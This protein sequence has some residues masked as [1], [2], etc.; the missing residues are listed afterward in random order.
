MS[1]RHFDLCREKLEA[2]PEL[3]GNGEVDEASLGTVR[4]IFGV[5]ELPDGLEM[6]EELQVGGDGRH[7]VGRKER[8]VRTIT[9]AENRRKSD[10]LNE[11]GF[12]N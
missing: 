7:Q 3:E 4:D 6:P 8:D 12:R 5:V 1:Q 10:H 9:F 11:N 2:G